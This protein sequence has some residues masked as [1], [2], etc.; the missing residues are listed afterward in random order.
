MEKHRRYFRANLLRKL[1]TVKRNHDVK[2]RQAIGYVGLHLD[3][4][5]VEAKHRPRQGP[6]QHS[7]R[8]LHDFVYR[9]VLAISKLMYELGPVNHR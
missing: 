9:R 5:P 3:P 8:I 2:P 1:W 6:G 4:D 7:G